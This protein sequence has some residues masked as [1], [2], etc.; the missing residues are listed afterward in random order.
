LLFVTQAKA[1]LDNALAMG[2][3]EGVSR[4]GETPLI[5]WFTNNGG[6]CKAKTEGSG[7]VAIRAFLGGA[8]AKGHGVR[9]ALAILNRLGKKKP[10]SPRRR[11]TRAGTTG[12]VVLGR[13][14]QDTAAEQIAQRERRRAK[15]VAEWVRIKGERKGAQVG[16]PLGGEQP[17]DKGISKASRTLGMT[18]QTVERS[19]KINGLSDAAKAEAARLDLAG[20]QKALLTAAE[21]EDPSAQVQAL[22]D[23]ADYTAPTGKKGVSKLYKRLCRD[24]DEA[25]DE[26]RAKFQS[27]GFCSCFAS[28]VE[29]PRANRNA[30][31]SQRPR[32]PQS[33]SPLHSRSSCVRFASSTPSRNSGQPSMPLA[34]KH[35]FT[36]LRKRQVYKMPNQIRNDQKALEPEVDM[37]IKI[38]AQTAASAVW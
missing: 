23:H 21:A 15:L 27:R 20:N 25:S 34:P 17:K 24:W 22:R 3:E 14:A 10:A 2:W 33:A 26:D 35:N 13:C 7:E 31:R 5:A 8:F 9:D 32:R 6:F 38:A 11:P 29:A 16:Q 1:Y 19:L 4:I 28:G 12:Q 30:L 37:R 18:R 36:W